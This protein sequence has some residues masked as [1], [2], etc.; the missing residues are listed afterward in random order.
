MVRRLLSYLIPI[1]I[2]RQRSD[3]SKSLEVT[4]ANGQLVL[5]SR[6]TNYSFGSLQRVLRKGLQHIGFKRIG[7]MERILVLGVAGG[8]VIRTINEETDFQ[9]RI[10]GVEIDG[11]VI[12]LANRYFG[13]GAIPNLELVQ[14]DAFEF[15]LRSNECY[16]L[17]IIDIF[18]DTKMPGFLF[19][20][21]FYDRLAKITQEGSS[22]LFN[23]MTL[24]DEDNLRNERFRRE[25]NPEYFTVSALKRMESHNEVLVIERI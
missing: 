23:T 22:I 18:Q 9:G 11:E 1:N 25:I 10:T 17:V 6:H 24:T 3:L 14:C 5:D 4:W 20:N 16:D 19:E 2:H 7:Q 21:F 15:V 12:A 13:L 8:S